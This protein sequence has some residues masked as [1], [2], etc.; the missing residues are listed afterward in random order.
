MT[1]P[2][3]IEL[4]QIG[5]PGWLDLWKD[6]PQD[7][8]IALQQ[9]PHYLAALTSLGAHLDIAIV[10]KR[11]QAVAFAP[12]AHNKF[13]KLFRVTS[14]F[15]G[16]VFLGPLTQDDKIQVYKVLKNLGNKLKWHFMN[17]QPDEEASKENIFELKKAGLTQVMTGFSTAWLD[18]RPEDR[19]LREGLNGKWRNQLKNAEQADFEI[20][21]SFD[22]QKNYQW[23]LSAE[24][25]HAKLK[26]YPNTPR[27]LIE[28]YELIAKNFSQ[29]QKPAV[30][31]VNAFKRREKL[32]GGL[33][34]L[35]GHSATY[36][37]GWI[38]E[39]GRKVNALNRILWEAILLLKL[40]GISFFD[41]GGLETSKYANLARFK[42][43]TGAI[44]ISYAGSFT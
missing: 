6:W 11:D 27:A 23:L 18:I 7:K 24:A 25:M 32:A 42:L 4:M 26:G 28:Q 41:L 14:C 8:P 39:E 30:L 31:N 21:H 5:E 20:S 15:R 16:P 1:S 43:G 9:H 10:K 35:H 19:L 37:I 22:K 3:T 13:Y 36:Q 40:Q 44:P 29:D 17:I 2:F 38:S 12:L 33:F 34:L